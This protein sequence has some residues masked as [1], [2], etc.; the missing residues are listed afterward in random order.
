[1]S[2]SRISILRVLLILPVL[3]L[4]LMGCVHS[5]KIHM[6]IDQSGKGTITVDVTIGSGG[7]SASANSIFET[8]EV[9]PNVL[10]NDG[11]Y[12]HSGTVILTLDDGTTVSY[13]G[14]LYYDSNTAVTPANS[15]HVALAYRPSNPVALQ[16][17]LDQ[18]WSRA[19]T[20]RVISTVGIRTVSSAST[21]TTVDVQ[22]SVDG[23]LQ[24]IGTG[25]LTTPSGGGPLQQDQ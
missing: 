1:M 6:G 14:S 3:A 8:R 17:F 11:G 12:P 19:V 10:A 22:S 13:S 24:Y 2:F 21:Y 9:D 23:Q 7:H 20:A 16:S 25:S 15:G 5:T 18:Y 4:P